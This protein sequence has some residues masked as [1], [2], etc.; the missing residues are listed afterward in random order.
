MSELR[1]AAIAFA[2]ANFQKRW[3]AES[4]RQLAENFAGLGDALFRQHG[5]RILVRGHRSNN[6]IARDVSGTQKNNHTQQSCPNIRKL[7]PHKTDPPFTLMTSPV[8]KLARSEARNKMG[9]S[10]SSAVAARPSGMAAAT[11]FWPAFELRTSLDISVATHPGATE[12]T[13]ML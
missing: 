4:I 7:Q 12:L 1:A 11:I 2:L 3:T 9:P 13:R 8:M 10:I 6:S 5:I